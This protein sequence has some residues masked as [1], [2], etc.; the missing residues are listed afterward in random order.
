MGRQTG[1]GGRYC[2][3]DFVKSDSRTTDAWKIN[4]ASSDYSLLGKSDLSVNDYVFLYGARS[5]LDSGRIVEVDVSKR[6][7][8]KEFSNLN[9]I[10][11][12]DYTDGDSGAPIVGAW[13]KTYGGMNIGE[14]GDYNYG[15]EWTFLKSKLSLQ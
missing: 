4:L 9:E 3:C 13:N 6:F 12:I 11:G 2:D 8:G 5:G 10:S 14:H 1:D 7:D 15:H